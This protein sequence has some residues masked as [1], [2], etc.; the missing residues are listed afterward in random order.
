MFERFTASA[1]EAVVL[2]QEE[3]RALRHHYLGTEHLL[4]GITRVDGPAA[5][6]LERLSIDAETVRADI[7]R[8]VG[9]GPEATGDDD[10]R[11][12]RTL[13][14]DLDEVRRRIEEEFGPGALDR[15][16]APC[17]R[18]G[19][20]WNGGVPFTPRAKKVLE[21]ALREAV[22]TRTGFIGT[23]HI[24]LGIV[25]EKDGLAARILAQREAPADTVRNALADELAGPEGLDGTSA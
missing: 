21:L 9:A 15:P 12:L 18:H 20:A 1:R 25:R 13:G 6:V 5:R 17:R 24:L 8:I 4:L 7:V 23:E 16:P 19:M 22:R 14:I 11:A 10:A 2:A 3:A